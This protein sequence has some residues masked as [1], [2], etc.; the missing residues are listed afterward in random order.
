MEELPGVMLFI[1][2]YYGKYSCKS[3][4]VQTAALCYGH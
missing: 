3:N 4:A 1:D 2:K